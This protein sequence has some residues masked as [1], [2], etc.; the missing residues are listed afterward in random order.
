MATVN[1]TLVSAAPW[2]WPSPVG[3]GLGILSVAVGQV[4]VVAY[5]FV[6]KS[7]LRHEP[8]R[9]QLEPRPYELMEGLSTHASQPEGFV[10]LG[11]YLCGTWMFRLLPESC[12]EPWMKGCENQQKI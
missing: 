6:R 12:V 9:I 4:L 5:H 11:L 2:E 7:V 8:P 3:L 1:A 10:L